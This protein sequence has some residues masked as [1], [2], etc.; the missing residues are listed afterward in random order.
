MFLISKLQLQSPSSQSVHAVQCVLRPSELHYVRYC[1]VLPVKF[2]L[3]LLIN[4]VKTVTVTC[5]TRITVDGTVHYLGPAFLLFYYSLVRFFS[6]RTQ[7]WSMLRL[8]GT[9][10]GTL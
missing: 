5:T 3:D 10:I 2:I 9:G 8:T 6:L 4:S 7:P 1:D